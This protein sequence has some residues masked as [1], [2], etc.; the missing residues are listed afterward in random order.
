M[1]SWGER[2]TF[3]LK[4]KNFDF[5]DVGGPGECFFHFFVLINQLINELINANFFFNQLI[6]ANFF[7]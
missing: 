2:N 7:D 1:Y 6:N 5:F 3:F 4:K